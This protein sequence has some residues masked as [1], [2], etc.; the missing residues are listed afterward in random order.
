MKPL[1]LLFDRPFEK[2]LKKFTA[3]L[4]ADQKLKFKQKLEILKE[5]IFDERLKTHKLKGNLR[6]YYAFS[7]SY[8]ERIVFKLLEDGGIYFIEIGG[9]EICY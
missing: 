2:K 3:Q 7:I 5:D 8:S 9:H 1:Y 6:D 4:T